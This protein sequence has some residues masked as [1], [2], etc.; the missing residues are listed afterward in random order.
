[1]TR[2][3]R[4]R[5]MSHIRSRD[6]GPE[7]AL[8]SSLWRKGGRGY[9]IHPMGVAGSPDI[10]YMGRKVATFLDDMDL[11][12]RRVGALLSTAKRTCV[13]EAL[14]GKHYVP[15]AIIPVGKY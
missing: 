5:T 1:M 9:R 7:L 11:A 3:Q 12:R 2:E 4:S 14:S 15:R 6:T 8:R 13:I 10:A